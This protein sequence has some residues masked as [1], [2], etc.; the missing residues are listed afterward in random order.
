MAHNNLGR[1]YFEQGRLDEAIAELKEAMS[2]DVEN[3][4]PHFN[5]GLI[6]R[7]QGLTDEAVAEFEACLALIPPDDPK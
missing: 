6:S 4:L 3:P 1:A 5:L 7:E 2:L